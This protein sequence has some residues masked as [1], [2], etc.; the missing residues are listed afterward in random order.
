MIREKAKGPF[1]NRA[2]VESFSLQT[3]DLTTILLLL[4]LQGPHSFPQRIEGI[5][6]VLCLALLSLAN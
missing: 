3:T 2:V 1:E 6:H 5:T 4:L